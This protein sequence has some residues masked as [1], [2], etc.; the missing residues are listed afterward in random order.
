MDSLQ[1]QFD[2]TRGIKRGSNDP[3]IS[4][5]AFTGDKTETLIREALQNVTGARD[6][7]KPARVE[8]ELGFMSPDIVPD[9][10]QLAHLLELSAE[11]L[12]DNG[13]NRPAEAYSAASHRL[14]GGNSI[15]ILRISDFETTGLTQ[16]RWEK[17]IDWIGLNTGNA[18]EPGAY[19]LGR[20]AFFSASRSRTVFYSSKSNNDYRFA[21]KCYFPSFKS[22]GTW[23]SG[24]GTFGE[25]NQKPATDINRI[26][27]YFRRTEQGT[28]IWVVDHALGWDPHK[29][30][31]ESVLNWF[32]PAIKWG[33]LEVKIGTQTF[34][35]DNLRESMLRYFSIEDRYPNPLPFLDAYENPNNEQPYEEE[36]ELLGAIQYF[37]LT[38][39]ELP[40]PSRTAYVRDAGMVVCYSNRRSLPVKFAGVFTC[41]NESG[42]TILRNLENPKHTE[43]NPSLWVDENGDVV[44]LGKDAISAIGAFV[45]SSVLDLTR[46]AVGTRTEL[47][48]LTG[49]DNSGLAAQ[50]SNGNSEN[51]IL[52]TEEETG[53]E[54]SAE[55]TD[56]SAGSHS[57]T[58]TRVPRRIIVTPT[59]IIDPP[60]TV[61]DPLPTNVD[62]TVKPPPTPVD[63]YKNINTVSTRCYILNN[64]G[65]STY[66]LVIKTDK[67]YAGVMVR[68]E[69][70]ARSDEGSAYGLEIISCIPEIG[71]CELI[72]NKIFTNLDS[73]GNCNFTVKLNSSFEVAPIIGVTIK[74]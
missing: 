22:D 34:T 73:N 9:H 17:L 67:K 32:W 14:L 62:G 71:D 29:K 46:L 72:N 38:S 21:G 60:P 58:P 20:G 63:S 66:R 33:I 47:V 54:I 18:N 5:F 6:N 40:Y 51:S 26:P 69:L 13:A 24:D 39:T 43:W 61:V 11:S 74:I 49:Q 7:D 57:I 15:P 41:R 30:I 31:A 37:G 36:N 23:K 25:E 44:Q 52:P 35:A 65:K 27:E 56:V 16:D 42:S 50:E 12:R 3:L 53:I 4:T 19:G 8:I 28:S 70:V 68:I 10:T 1:Y 59:I 48:G 2:I 45:D 64:K 55:T